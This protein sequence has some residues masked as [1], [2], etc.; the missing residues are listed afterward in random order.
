MTT[1]EAISQLKDLMRDRESFF[2]SD[3]D[4]DIFRADAKACEIAIEALEKQ[5]PKKP[6]DIKTWAY[7]TFKGGKCCACGTNVNSDMNY[8]NICGQAF[9]WS[10]GWNEEVNENV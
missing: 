10:F 4:N 5:T 3:G 2:N 8:C 7:D 9:D 1:K 6:A